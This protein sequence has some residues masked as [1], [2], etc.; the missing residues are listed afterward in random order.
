MHGQDGNQE[1]HV[2]IRVITLNKL[3]IFMEGKVLK[4]L[5]Y[6]NLTGRCAMEARASER[7]RR[8]PLFAVS[9]LGVLP[10]ATAPQVT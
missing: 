10:A 3:T 4:W 7:G 8:Q 2:N 9:L 6:K 5:K 1:T